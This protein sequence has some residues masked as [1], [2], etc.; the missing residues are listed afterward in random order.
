MPVKKRGQKMIARLN[1]KQAIFDTNKKMHSFF[2]AGYR[3]SVRLFFCI[4]IILQR[5][6]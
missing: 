2:F 5:Q 3:H 4:E 1:C 6:K